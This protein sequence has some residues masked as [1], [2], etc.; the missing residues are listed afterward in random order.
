MDAADVDAQDPVQ[1]W[2]ALSEGDDPTQQ[3]R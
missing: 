1:E 3:P 2:D